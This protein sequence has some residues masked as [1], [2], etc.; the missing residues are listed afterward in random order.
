MC[1]RDLRQ[2]FNQHLSS[3][4]VGNS[5][6]KA[7]KEVHDR[8]F[9]MQALRNAEAEVRRLPPEKVNNYGSVF[10]T[11][12]IVHFMCIYIY[13]LSQTTLLATETIPQ[14]KLGRAKRVK[15]EGTEKASALK[16]A[17]PSLS[18]AEVGPA[19]L[20]ADYK[21]RDAQEVAA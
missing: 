7:D 12:Y 10:F 19:W 3:H 17:H 1:T 8:L 21:P 4:L 18:A 6:E 2:A 5:I 14:V 15:E 16:E 20:W 13:Q 9:T 11:L